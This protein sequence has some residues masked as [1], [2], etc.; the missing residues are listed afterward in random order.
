[1]STWVR[2]MLGVAGD[3]ERGDQSLSWEEGG[4]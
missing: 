4:G 1:M 3:T 2:R